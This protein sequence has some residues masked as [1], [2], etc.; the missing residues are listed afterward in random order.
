[1]RFDH[2]EAGPQPQVEGVAEHDLRADVDQFCRCHRLHG[3]VS[4][5]RHEC[6]RLD[7]AVRQR[8]AT[9]SRGTVGGDEFELNAHAARS[10]SIASP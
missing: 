10:S 2:L 5:D 8:Q 7:R 1:M 3:A 6:R 4:A 9:A